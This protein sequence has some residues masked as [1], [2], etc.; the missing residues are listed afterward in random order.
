MGKVKMSFPCSLPAF[1]PS[2]FPIVCKLLLSTYCTPGPGGVPDQRVITEITKPGAL[3][4]HE[5]GTATPC[6]ME[7]SGVRAQ[8]S[9]FIAFPGL[10]WTK[11][12]HFRVPF[13]TQRS[14]SSKVF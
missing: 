7:V 12:L 6:G 1:L 13:S 5:G 3:R 4:E 8:R 10:L 9:I 11:P 2:F 14:H